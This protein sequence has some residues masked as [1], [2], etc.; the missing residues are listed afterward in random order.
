VHPLRDRCGCFRNVRESAL[1]AEHALEHR[2]LV[3]D[4]CSNTLLLDPCDPD[5]AFDFVGNGASRTP[6]CGPPFGSR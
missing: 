4:S 1:A 2:L 6:F 3:G 5:M